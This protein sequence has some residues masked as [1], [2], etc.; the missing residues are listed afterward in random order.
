MAAMLF[1]LALTGA[2]LFDLA[3]L[4]YPDLL[5]FAAILDNVRLFLSV[6]LFVIV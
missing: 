5:I 1:V 3:I 6:L 2:G 4:G